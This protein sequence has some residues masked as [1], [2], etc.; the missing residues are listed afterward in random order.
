MTGRLL[1]A[2]AL[3]MPALFA[4]AANP[5]SADAKALWTQIKTNNLKAAEKMPES[6]YGFKPTPEVRSY[7]QLVAHIADGNMLICGGA[8]GE[9]QRP[10]A[11][12]TKTTKADI[13]AALQESIAYCDAVY[14]A[15][16]DAEATKIIKLFGRDRTKITALF[17]NVSHD[18]EHYGNQVTYLRLKGIV[19]P[20]SEPR[21]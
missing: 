21:R 20:S 5:L 11:E 13:I 18:N 12:K 4:Q 19:P 3:A 14:D 15:M 6:E 2:A 10:A 8:K 1:L 7:G 17:V 16:T 9:A